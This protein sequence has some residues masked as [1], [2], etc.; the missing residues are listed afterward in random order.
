MEPI[1]PYQ[2]WERMG[3]Q[4]SAALFERLFQ[5][6]PRKAID[7]GH[8]ILVNFLYDFHSTK[9]HNDKILHKYEADDRSW[10]TGFSGKIFF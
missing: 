3:Q 7:L 2:A 5:T 9:K 1:N 4:C 8:L 10:K 6:V